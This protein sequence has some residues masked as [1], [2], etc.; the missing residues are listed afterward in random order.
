MSRIE[1]LIKEK[2]PDGVEYKKIES[3]CKLQN[4]FAFKSSSFGT[5]QS[6]VLKITNICGDGKVTINTMTTIDESEYSK[7]NFEPYRVKNGDIVVALSGATTGK[8]GRNL[9]HEDFLLNQRVAKFVPS[10]ELLASYLYH[11]IVGKSAFLLTLAGG[12]AQPNLST[13]SIEEIEIPVPPIEVQ[14][15]IVCIF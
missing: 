13:K 5:G 9:T 10:E 3:V 7:T 6:K 12:G 14:Q 15:E 8:I 4:G 2:C 11:Y 1:E